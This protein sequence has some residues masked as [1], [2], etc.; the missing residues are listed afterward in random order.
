M[1]LRYLSFQ[2]EHGKPLSTKAGVTVE[3]LTAGGANAVFL[4]IGNTLL[5]LNCYLFLLLI[6]VSNFCTY[7]VKKAAEYFLIWNIFLR[8]K[9]ITFSILQFHVFSMVWFTSCIVKTTIVTIFLEYTIV[10]GS[11]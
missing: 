6:F 11:F 5:F 1:Q 8:S 3:S 7:I 9:F 10:Y 4:G 2:V